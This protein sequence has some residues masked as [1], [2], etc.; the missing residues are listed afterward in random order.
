LYRRRR[1]GNLRLAVA[2]P[3]REEINEWLAVNSMHIAI[4]IIIII[5]VVLLVF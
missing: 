1:I 2:L 3:D 5:I 4:V